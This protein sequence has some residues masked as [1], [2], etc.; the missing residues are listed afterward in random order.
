MDTFDLIITNPLN[1]IYQSNTVSENLEIIQYLEL[2]SIL[3]KYYNVGLDSL[4]IQRCY[5]DWRYV[6][7]VD[8]GIDGFIPRTPY[9]KLRGDPNWKPLEKIE[10][11]LLGIIEEKRKKSLTRRPSIT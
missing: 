5:A 7:P 2:K 9:V 3:N 4:L 8:I 11:R 1:A 10:E 6:V